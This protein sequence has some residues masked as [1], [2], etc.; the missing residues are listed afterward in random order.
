MCCRAPLCTPAGLG[1]GRLPIPDTDPVQADV[2]QQCAVRPAGAS[3]PADRRPSLAGKPA[4]RRA[5]PL[6]VPLPQQV[7]GR[8]AGWA[9]W[10][11]G[12]IACL[13][14]LPVRVCRASRAA[15][16]RTLWGWR[17]SRISS[18]RTAGEHRGRATRGV[19]CARS[20]MHERGGREGVPNARQVKRHSCAHA[21]PAAPATLPDAAAH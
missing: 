15:H 3:R 1:H 7:A 19:G 16:S 17:G 21:A 14:S 8:T 6:V 11:G 18:T 13:P 12:L 20:W 4:A 2:R 10:H 9:G 5:A